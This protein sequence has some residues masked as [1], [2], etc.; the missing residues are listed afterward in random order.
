MPTQR[1]AQTFPLEKPQWQE[2]VP[3]LNVFHANSAGQRNKR[4]QQQLSMAE[5]LA[6]I[7]GENEAARDQRLFDLRQA[8]IDREQKRDSNELGNAMWYARQLGKSAGI[9]GLTPVSDQQYAALA[10]AMGPEK[11]MAFIDSQQFA[12]R[13]TQQ[14]QQADFAQSSLAERLSQIRQQSAPERNQ[15]DLERGRLTN[16]GIERENRTKGVL[17][18][19]G[20]DVFINA[21]GSF[22]PSINRSPGSSK[23]VRVARQVPRIIN[24]KPFGTETVFEDQLVQSPPSMSVGNI[25]AGVGS[26]G[27]RYVG[28][29]NNPQ[30]D[31]PQ[32]FDSS[33]ELGG[34]VSAP[35]VS[36]F[37]SRS[38]YEP[39]STFSKPQTKTDTTPTVMQHLNSVGSYVSK[40]ID[41]LTSALAKTPQ[42]VTTAPNTLANSL[43]SG[44]E[45]VKALPSILPSRASG[46][47]AM[48]AAGNLQPVPY[49]QS[50]TNLPP[51]NSGM[52][53]PQMRAAGVQPIPQKLS[54]NSQG[55]LPPSYFDLSPRTPVQQPSVQQQP[56]YNGPMAFPQAR[57]ASPISTAVD[58]ILSKYD[59]IPQHLQQFESPS[60]DNEALSVALSQAQAADTSAA[61]TSAYMGAQ[62]PMGSKSMSE[63]A[64]ALEQE[65]KRQR[66]P[67]SMPTASQM[68]QDMMNQLYQ[69][70][71]SNGVRPA[72]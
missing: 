45:A 26:N 60:N 24:G 1:E 65:Q 51:S 19:V 37:Y 2:Y 39:L 15:I 58:D 30:A 13:N 3:F 40:G 64:Q 5:A 72:Y 32:A 46:T 68:F 7:R 55:M 6:R 52:L 11:A 17:S 62:N 47:P 21:D 9:K 12:E 56:Q 59:N 8:A 29:V 63:L 34:S 70:Y 41:N 36:P 28:N 25:T 69:P 71:P 4:V 23:V 61:G 43:K 33:P 18:G 10:R 38:D 54:I 20:G 57:P 22:G 50:I 67:G 66:K 27:G 48:Q 42:G 31:N 14:S 44:W 35:K 16:A 49:E 53:T